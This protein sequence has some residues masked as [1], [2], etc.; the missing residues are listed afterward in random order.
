MAVDSS[1]EL[2]VDDRTLSVVGGEPPTA[3]QLPFSA[4]AGA[5]VARRAAS[6]ELAGWLAGSYAEL[7]IPV[8]GVEGGRADEL[9]ERLAR[10]TGS[11]AARPPRQRRR[12]AAWLIVALSALGIAATLL[13]VLLG[14]STGGSGSSGQSA[15]E[16]SATR[17]RGLVLGDLPS[18]WGLDNPATA[19]LSGLLS[20]SGG[21]STKAE[22]AAYATVVAEYQRCMGLSD[23]SDRVFGKAGVTPLLQVSSKPFATIT[24]SAYLEA[25]TVTQLYSSPA[26]VAKDLTQLRSASFPGCFAESLGRLIMESSSP[27]AITASYQITPQTLPSSLGAFTAGAN[28]LV[29]LSDGAGSTVPAEIGV[30]AIVH[31]PYEQTL[32]TFSTPGSF[33][34]ALRD[35]LVSILAGRLVGAAGSAST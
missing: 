10:A 20:T 35:R 7:S 32:Y 14:S 1:V 4:L 25:G 30:T 18:G 11:A 15:A 33:P 27:S 28:V 24:S 16:R 13:I 9:F 8:E 31:A 26:D 3:W 34:T 19:P 29:Q 2:R 12:R 5:S 23:A 17:S 22:R 21:S 6:I